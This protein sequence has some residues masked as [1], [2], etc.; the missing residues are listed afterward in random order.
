MSPL[1]GR[2]AIGP[3][4]EDMW[5]FWSR[6][7]A[8]SVYTMPEVFHYDG[9]FDVAAAQFALDATVRRHE[10]LRTVFRETDT[11]VVPVIQDPD[12]VPVEVLDLRDSTEEARPDLL[13]AAIDTVSARPFDLT[14]GPPIRLA[15]IPVSAERTWLVLVVHQ[16]ACDGESMVVVL[17]EFGELYRSARRGTAPDLGP[18][19]PGYGVFVREQLTALADGGL[20]EEAKFWRERLAGMSGS[21]LPGTDQAAERNSAVSGTTMLPTTLPNELS[22][23]VRAF[24]RRASVTP[25]GVLLC[26]M[27]VMIAAATGDGDVTLGTMTSVRPPRFARTVGMLTNMVVQRSRIDLS[28]SFADVLGDVSLDLMDSIDYQE[29]PFTRAVAGLREPGDGL[30]RTTFSAGAVGGLTLDGGSVSDVVTAA[31]DG[32]Y[33]L[34]AVCEITP[35]H[36]AVDWKF[37]RCTYSPEAAHGYCAAYQEILAAALD[38]P[39]AAMDSLGLSGIAARAVATG[40]ERAPEAV[41]SHSPRAEDDR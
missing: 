39:E 6:H 14:A 7:R 24:A 35:A 13:R 26:A 32:L 33:D 25:F 30:I 10:A 15:A 16:I 19:A 40:P 12:S 29:L 31:A 17:E 37:A 8:S 38:R 2:S 36:I 27:D 23:A 3:L 34:A 1:T 5:L 21:V 28:R 4:Q 22:D 18:D 41:P 9:A 20:E 11:G